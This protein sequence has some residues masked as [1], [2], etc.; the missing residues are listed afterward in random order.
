LRKK[1]NLEK[2]EHL[3]KQFLLVF[4]MGDGRGMFWKKNWYGKAGLLFFSRIISTEDS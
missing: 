1:D 3:L 2:E 4:N